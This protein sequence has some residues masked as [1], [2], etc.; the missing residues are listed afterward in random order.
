MASDVET[1]RALATVTA[2]LDDQQLDGFDSGRVQEIVTQAL[3]GEASLT[4]DDGGGLHDQTG[5]RVGA[6]RRTDSGEWIAER[7]NDTA[8]RSDTAIPAEP[9]QSK[10]R[11]AL[12][13][14]K[15]LKP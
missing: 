4:V 2:T 13:K 15:S 11:A 6:I 7:Q 12:T 8:E 5:T 9:P 1:E 10:L 3:G 14:V